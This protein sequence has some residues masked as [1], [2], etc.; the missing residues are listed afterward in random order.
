MR[1]EKKAVLSYQLAREKGVGYW[2]RTCYNQVKM[3]YIW[4]KW[5]KR[6]GTMNVW[7]CASKMR[8]S[9]NITRMFHRK[10]LHSGSVTTAGSAFTN[11][12]Q[13]DIWN[14][15]RITPVGLRCARHFLL[16]HEKKT[17]ASLLWGELYETAFRH[18]GLKTATVLQLSVDVAECVSNIFFNTIQ[19][20]PQ[21]LFP[22]YLANL[23][24]LIS[25]NYSTN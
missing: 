10:Y 6:A 18:D 22:L 23:P 24:N 12:T 8:R 9:R 25:Q 16:A 17:S 21:R 19:Q 14:G 15:A 11:N 3:C 7:H 4:L 5:H 2:G 13:P 1:G 20:T